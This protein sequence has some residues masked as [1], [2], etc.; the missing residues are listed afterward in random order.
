MVFSSPCLRLHFGNCT[1]RPVIPDPLL[2][3]GRWFVARARSGRSLGF[4]SASRMTVSTHRAE[5]PTFSLRP[6][7]LR[8]SGS[9]SIENKRRSIITN[10]ILTIPVAYTDKADVEKKTFRRVGVVFEN[11]RN[12]G[13]G[14]KLLNIKLDFPIGVTELVGF[15]PKA[16][17][18]A[19]E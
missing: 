16:D 14:E 9:Q 10:Y 8:P 5:P 7:L 1:S 19:D 15:P 2:F 12:D 18:T 4:A 11:T 17:E 6:D 3:S 13:S